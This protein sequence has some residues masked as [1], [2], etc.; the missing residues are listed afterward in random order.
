MT[1]YAKDFFKAA[2]GHRRAV[3]VLIDHEFTNGKRQ[4]VVFALYNCLGF[5]VELYLKAFLANEGVTDDA[6]MKKP[7]GH[8]LRQLFSEAKTRSFNTELPAME[9]IIHFLHQDHSKY[10]YRYVPDGGDLMV[11][12]DLLP[13]ISALR[14]VHVSMQNELA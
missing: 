8:N 5:A 3:E 4:P 14:E 7:Y 9:R 13:V 10:T 2:E 12:N 11:F 1:T 6:L